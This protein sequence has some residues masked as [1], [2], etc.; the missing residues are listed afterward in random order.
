MGC[1][2]RAEGPTARD[3]PAENPRRHARDGAEERLMRSRW[4]GRSEGRT[5]G[6]E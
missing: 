2:A 1:L 6:T 4:A 5:E 3:G